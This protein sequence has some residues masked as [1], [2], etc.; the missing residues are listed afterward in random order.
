MAQNVPFN[1]PYYPYEK[2]QTG[3]STFRGWEDIPYKIITYLLDL[4]DANG[5]MPADDNSRP[6][7]RLA[8]YLWYDGARPL[9]NPLPTPAQKLSMLFDPE[10]PDINTDEDKQNHPQGYRI[11]PQNSIGQSQ[12]DAETIIYCYIGRDTPYDNFHSRTAIIFEIWTNVNLAANTKTQHYTRLEAIEQAIKEAL[13][14][15]NITGV[16]TIQYS[17][18]FHAD[19][20][21]R[22]IWDSH[23]N[24][25]RELTLALLWAE[26]GPDDGRV[27]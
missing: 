18:R 5:Y 14:G 2:D 12:L 8:K 7:V 21:S 24:P 22:T 25:G 10:H 1:S 26:S 15:V 20:G 19:C 16:G 4:P 27:Y 17:Q 23:V 11:F 6:R 9:D 13:I 3:Y